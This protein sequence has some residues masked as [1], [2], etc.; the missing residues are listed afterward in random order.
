DQPGGADGARQSPDR[1]GRGGGLAP[2]DVPDRGAGGQRLPRGRQRAGQGARRSS[3][4]TST[5]GASRSSLP[6]STSCMTT[7]AVHT[8]V[9]EPIWKT[10][11]SV[12]ST[13]V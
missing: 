1:G 12:A 10:E 7:V 6:S 5:S 3:G 8:L 11:S 4:S 9:M 2:G 13:P